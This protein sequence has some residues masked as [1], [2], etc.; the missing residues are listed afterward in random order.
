M[1]F[2]MNYK[3]Y[4][5]GFEMMILWLIITIRVDYHFISSFALHKYIT[6]R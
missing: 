4:K 1:H 6:N 2:L 3:K 5:Q